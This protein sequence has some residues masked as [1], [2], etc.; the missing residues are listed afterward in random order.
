MLTQTITKSKQV[1][2]LVK[3]L[4]SPNATHLSNISIVNKTANT[5]FTIFKINI[6]SSLSW[7]KKNWCIIS[8]E[9]DFYFTKTWYIRR[10][11]KTLCTCK[12]MS[13][14]HKLRL[15]ANISK[16]IVHSKKGLSTKSNITCLHISQHRPRHVPRKQKHHGRLKNDILI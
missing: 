1:Q 11:H 3:Y 8:Y 13:S 14:K 7:K 6:N 15:E 16:R 4:Q 9:K 10:V 12:L 5:M 2:A